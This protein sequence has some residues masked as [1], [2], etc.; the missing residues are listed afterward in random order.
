M[1]SIANCLSYVVGLC[2]DDCHGGSSCTLHDTAGQVESVSCER[3]SVFYPLFV[4][5]T[6]AY[7]RVH[8]CCMTGLHALGGKGLTDCIIQQH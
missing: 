3:V 7:S 5:I 4:Y 2:G 1:C 6:C 8:Q